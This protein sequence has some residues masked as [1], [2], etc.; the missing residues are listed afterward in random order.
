M[1]T[2][3]MLDLKKKCCQR[4]KAKGNGPTYHV[5]PESPVKDAIEA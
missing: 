5:L 3:D 1:R 2:M 4:P